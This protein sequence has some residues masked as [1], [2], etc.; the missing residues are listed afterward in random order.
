MMHQ[1]IN[2]GMTLTFEFAFWSWSKISHN[3]FVRINSL[4]FDMD[5]IKTRRHRYSTNLK[6]CS[7]FTNCKT[8]KV[9]NR[10]LSL[11]YIHIVYMIW[12]FLKWNIIRLQLTDFAD[13][14]TMSPIKSFESDR[15]FTYFWYVVDVFK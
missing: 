1:G 4:L 13:N 9:I 7:S 3:R 15:D 8:Y 2:L 5:P 11:V 12:I 6:W 10:T 14:W